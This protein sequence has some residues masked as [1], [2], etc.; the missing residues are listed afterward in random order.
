MQPNW[1]DP[2]YTNCLLMSNLFV[3]VPVTYVPAPYGHLCTVPAP[4][5]FVPVQVT[6]VPALVTF[7]P[8]PV[9]FVPAPVTFSA[10][11]FLLHP[12]LF[13][14]LLVQP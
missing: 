14:L 6:F 5:T 4:V 7:V 8:G 3:S 1:P 9:P 2:S 13:N 10:A 12:V 11:D